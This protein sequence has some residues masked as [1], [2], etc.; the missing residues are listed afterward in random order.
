MINKIQSL[1]NIR[2]N[3]GKPALLLVG[4]MFFST[5][6]YSLGGTGIEALYFARF[7][8]DLL[9]YLYMGLGILSLITTLAITGLLGR[10]KRER[11]YVIVPF[12]AAIF[13]LIAWG[14]L[15]SNSK[16][17]YP[18]L[19]LGKEV[20]NTVVSM[21]AWNT[22]GVVCDSRM[23]KRLFPL[24]N[25][26]RIL[27]AV[28]SGL[29]TGLLVKF[30]G[31]QNLVFVWALSMGMVFVMTRILMRGKYISE[32]R[33]QKRRVK[34][35]SSSF[36][37]EMVKGWHYV[38][39]SALMRWMSLASILFSILYFS[40]ALPF[41]RSTAMQYPNENEL[42]SFLGLFNGLSTAAAFI[43]SI[44]FANR[45]FARYG[46]MSM[47]LVFP[48]I[49]L[50][51]FG[52]L[53]IFNGFAII[54]AFRF[55]QTIWLSGI[56][57]SAYQ[58]VFSA[59][60]PEKRDQVNA[61]VNGVPEQ[62]GV[63]LAGGILIIGETSFTTQQLYLV[64]LVS[65]ITT[66][67]II[68][69]AS[70][71]YR[72]A[73][74]TS[75]QEGR[76]TI[77][78]GRAT[79]HDSTS[80]SVALENIKHPDP[81][82][83]RVSVEM[84]G[85]M[86]NAGA[87]IPAL[88]DNDIDVRIAALK[89]LVH[90]VPALVEVSALL[91]DSEPAIRQQAIRTLRVLSPDPQI[92]HNFIEPILH[93]KETHVQ[94][95]AA[96]GL[97]KIDEHREARQLIRDICVNGSLDERVHALNAMSELG[98]R[99]AYDLIAAQL[100]DHDASIRRAAAL[101]LASCGEHAIPVLINSLNDKNLSVREGIGQALSK[102]GKESTLPA[103]TALNDETRVDGALLALS[104]L[105]VNGYSSEIKTFVAEKIKSALYYDDLARKIIPV[106][107]RLGLLVD[108]IRAHAQNAG[109]QALQALSLLNDRE[110]IKIAIDNLQSKESTQRANALETLESIRDSNL[111]R[112]LIHLWESS[113]DENI[114]QTDY[115][116]EVL[117]KLLIETDSWLR[118]CA[119][120]AL[121]N[122]K[123][124][125][126][127][128]RLTLPIMERVLLL[129][130]VLLL[131]DLTPTDLQRVATLATEHHVD[132]NEVIFEQ[133]DSGDE[134]YV[135]VRGEVKVMIS[136]NGENEREVARRKMGDVVGEMA[137]ISG[138][139]RIAT[140]IANGEVH[141][142][143]LDRKSFEGLLRERPEV[144]LAVMRVLC[145][146]LKEATN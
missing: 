99:E 134:M 142:L 65:A 115:A 1:L 41:S 38:R 89:G 112:P 28:L 132:D 23:A 144:S 106:N 12:I 94:I 58:T 85:E 71:A 75:L 109:T 97:L 62:A 91:T 30:I 101:A 131:A 27:G 122:T 51:G 137:I 78:S 86:N 67:F 140:L 35:R 7:G 48:L 74:V 105:P 43:T 6:G 44:F 119:A 92:M 19:W 83:R 18:S 104:Y 8:T 110:S 5:A 133:G 31:T 36:I 29:G 135:I 20:L 53:T 26:S 64:G 13:L 59:V 141:L 46:I 114:F 102:I 123:G 21:I 77:F 116:Q 9:P 96:L 17:I 98:D 120:F 25:A 22:A 16:F 61:F 33:R 146:R 40:I 66:T 82:V 68:W 143:C 63:F 128:T 121:E 118:D 39:A 130:H 127:D 14:L 55:V 45:L 111:I 139:P 136:N 4:I 69:R 50:F 60:P 54:V 108:S 93:D 79:T 95:E 80:I 90:H 113:K 56:A 103:I 34:R 11:M 100:Q 3:E 138:E 81:L 73:L 24:F 76:P 88:Q 70:Y 124:E 87:L 15:F 32:P 72:V 42:V 84:L 129:R 117:P 47:I 125:P 49:Y 37:N 107:E 2:A 145:A 10:I 57:D 52:A 126:M